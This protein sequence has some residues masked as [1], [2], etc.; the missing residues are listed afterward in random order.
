MHRWV[1][2]PHHTLAWRQWHYRNFRTR[3]PLKIAYPLSPSKLNKSDFRIVKTHKLSYTKFEP[4]QDNWSNRAWV[5]LQLKVNWSFPQLHSW[6]KQLCADY[7]LASTNMSRPSTQLHRQAEW[8]HSFLFIN[9]K[10][11]L[12]VSEK[13][14]V[15]KNDFTLPQEFDH[16]LA[17]FVLPRWTPSFRL[18]KTDGWCIQGRWQG[19]RRKS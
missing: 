9:A 11:K 1:H 3:Q 5:L 16:V 18:W 7:S 14:P 15:R 19:R 2:K 17:K 6:N 4:Q 8:Y 13:Q 10:Y 12:L